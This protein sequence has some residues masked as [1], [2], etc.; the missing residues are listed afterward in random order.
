MKPFTMQS[1]NQVIAVFVLLCLMQTVMLAQ[2]EPPVG[3]RQNTPT[4]HA[5]TNAK[6]V[7]AP[8]KV[9]DKGTLVIRD[10]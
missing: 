10:G 7:T 4:V 1:F 6:I 5:F 2:T 8:G 3:I 9:I